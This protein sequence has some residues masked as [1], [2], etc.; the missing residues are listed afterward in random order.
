VDPAQFNV[1]QDI[2]AFRHWSSVQK[3]AEKDE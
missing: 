2:S 1:A 3:G